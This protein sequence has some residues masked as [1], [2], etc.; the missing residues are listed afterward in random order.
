MGMRLNTFAIFSLMALFFLLS[1]G[2]SCNKKNKYVPVEENPVGPQFEADSAFAYCYQQC[3]FGPRAMNSS[4]HDECGKWIAGK[5]EALGCEVELQEAS[6]QGYDGTALRSTNIIAHFQPDKPRHVL[7]CA[8]WDSRP[9]ADNDPDSTHWRQPIIG[10]N[11]GASGVAVLLEVA[12]LLQQTDSL[13]LGVDSSV[14]TPRTGECLSGATTVVRTHGPWDHSTGLP[15]IRLPHIRLFL[16]SS[17][18]W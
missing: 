14:S 9:W 15:F 17:L 5:F 16:E 10:A 3:A 4:A 7:L 18:T 1:T 11:D 2:S 8:H 12:R 13:D 6:L